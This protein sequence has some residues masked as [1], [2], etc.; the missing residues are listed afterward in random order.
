VQWRGAHNPSTKGKSE[1]AKWEVEKGEE[2]GGKKTQTTLSHAYLTMIII[3][4]TRT[5]EDMG[6]PGI[7]I[8]PEK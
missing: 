6:G 1:G 5:K 8:V 7:E 4:T 3:T 2:R